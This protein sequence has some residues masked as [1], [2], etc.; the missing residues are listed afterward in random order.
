MTVSS[1]KAPHRLR[2]HRARGSVLLLA[3]FVASCAALP[4]QPT[5][6]R[7]EANGTAPA[8]DY[9]WRSVVVG[10]GGYVT[11]IVIHPKVPDRAGPSRPSFRRAVTTLSVVWSYVEPQ[12]RSRVRRRR[13]WMMRSGDYSWPCCLPPSSCLP[14]LSSLGFSPSSRPPLPRLRARSATVSVSIGGLSLAQ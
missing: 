2:L 4:T 10:G 9:T 1:P 14:S 7:P 12:G 5:A 8:A 3:P 11:G 6:R 13:D